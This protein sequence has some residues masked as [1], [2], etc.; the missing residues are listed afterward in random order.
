MK[1][2]ILIIALFLTLSCSKSEGNSSFTPQIITPVLIDKGMIF[3]SSYNPTQHG[4]IISLQTEWDNFR[5]SYWI[6]GLTIAE[7]NNVNF[8]TEMIVLVFDNPRT[9]G[10]YDALINTITE[11]TTNI[12]VQVSYTG[13]GDATQMPTRPYHFV[14]IPLSAKP[15]LFQ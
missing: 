8:S 7:A 5:N 3:N 4:E 11:N 10:G 1:N 12:V 6:D 15:V 9:T 14:K 2:L 13:S